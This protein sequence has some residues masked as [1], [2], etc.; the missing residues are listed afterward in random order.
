MKKILLVLSLFVFVGCSSDKK[1]RIGS[2]RINGTDIS[3]IDYS[4]EDSKSIKL[5]LE[6]KYGDKGDSSSKRGFNDLDIRIKAFQNGEELLYDANQSSEFTSKQY[7]GE[8]NKTSLGFILYNQKDI[9]E[10]R[11]GDSNTMDTPGIFINLSNVNNEKSNGLAYYKNEYFEISNYFYDMQQSMVNGHVDD[12]LFTNGEIKKLI[13]RM[14]DNLDKFPVDDDF[15]IIIKDLTSNYKELTDLV[16]SVYNDPKTADNKKI[17][18]ISY[19]IGKYSSNLSDKY[20]DG[21][22]PESLLKME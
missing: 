21:E 15:L 10:V 2:E 13:Q 14:N 8:E 11:F 20:Y 12:V 4:I 18:D 6:W 5:N 22:I 9:V 17:Y 19:N 1:E 16:D 7:D 3:V